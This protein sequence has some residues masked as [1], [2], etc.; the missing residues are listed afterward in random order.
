M[1]RF[2]GQGFAQPFALS[3]SAVAELFAGGCR[4]TRQDKP[5]G[6]GRA[7][8][9]RFATARRRTSPRPPAGQRAARLQL[10]YLGVETSVGHGYVADLG[11]KSRERHEVSSTNFFSSILRLR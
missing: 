8:L 4:D 3:A 5:I 7:A 9:A 1:L 6:A 10:V 2:P 11:L